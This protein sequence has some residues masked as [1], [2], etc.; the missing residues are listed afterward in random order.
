LAQLSLERLK[1]F[2]LTK[3]KPAALPQTKALQAF[4]LNQTTEG[5]FKNVY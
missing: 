2:Y 4:T 5:K 1:L 3:R